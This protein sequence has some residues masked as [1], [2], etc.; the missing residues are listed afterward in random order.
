MVIV[1]EHTDHVV[2]PPGVDRG[3]PRFL[4]RGGV[5]DILL[6]VLSPE[7]LPAM[8][9]EPTHPAVGAVRGAATAT[10]AHRVSAR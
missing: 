1:G 9:P 6:P 3:V 5:P 10:G 2:R 4:H 8:P 7:Q